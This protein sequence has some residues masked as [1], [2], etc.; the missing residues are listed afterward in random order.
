LLPKYERKNKWNGQNNA[1]YATMVENVDAQIGR[2]IDL[3]EKTGK[4][5]NTFIL[6]TSDNGGVYKVT[7]QLPLRTEK[8]SLYEGGIR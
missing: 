3:L 5:E 6:F 1:A 8:G 2:L 7:K 4:I